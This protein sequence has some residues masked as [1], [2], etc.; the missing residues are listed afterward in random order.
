MG[1]DLE[2]H[3]VGSPIKP[4][5]ART[6]TRARDGRLDCDTT[7]SVH[8][9]QDCFDKSRVSRVV[10][11]RRRLR[12]D[13]D[14]EVGAKGSR[15]SRTDSRRHV[16]IALLDTANDRPRNTDGPADGRLADAGAQADLPEFFPESGAGP[17]QLTVAIVDRY[18]AQAVRGAEPSE[19]GRLAVLSVRR[20]SQ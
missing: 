17:S 14:A 9:P 10:D 3:D 11:Q 18:A 6:A 4:D 16:R 5:V 7:A 15:G 12:I 1:L 19:C 13:G 20:S 8:E 2:D